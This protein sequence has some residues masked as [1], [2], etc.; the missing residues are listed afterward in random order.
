[1]GAKNESIFC[2]HLLSAK[3]SEVTPCSTS[4]SQ[5]FSCYRLL[6]IPPKPKFSL[7]TSAVMCYSTGMKMLH[8][9]ALTACVAALTSCET[10]NP[11]GGAGSFHL[12]AAD[13]ARHEAREAQKAQEMAS[14]Q[15]GDGGTLLYQYNE[16]EAFGRSSST[17]VIRS[18]GGVQS[19]QTIGNYPVQPGM[20]IPGY[21]YPGPS[22]NGGPGTYIDAR[23]GLLMYRR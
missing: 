20:I 13:H 12:S 19:Y 14:S 3:S 18:A 16:S 11:P 21:N 4:R 9:L 22:V 1:M 15:A 2:P 17:G 10:A 7:N 6:S 23:T 5:G 8:S